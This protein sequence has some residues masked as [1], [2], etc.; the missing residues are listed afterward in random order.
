MPSEPAESN[1]KSKVRATAYPTRERNGVVWAY[2]GPRETPPPLPELE[3]NLRPESLVTTIQRE[4][5]YM[6][7]LEGDIDTS[8]LAFLHLGAKR[9]DDFPQGSFDYYTVKDRTPRYSVVET[10]YGTSYGA[11]RPAEPDTTYWRIAHFLFPF[12]T[13]IPTGLLGTQV[14]VRAWVPIDDDHTMFWSMLVPSSRQPGPAGF[15]PAASQVNSAPD[16]SSGRAFASVGPRTGLE[17]L[18]NSSDWLGRW[19]LEANARNDYLIDRQ[20]QAQHRA[21]TG[22]AGIHTQDQAITESMGPVYD[23][24]HEHLGTSDSMVI[25]TRR[26]LIRA[27]LALRDEQV[28]PPAVDQPDLYLQRSGGT[29]LPRS[30]DWLTATEELRRAPLPQATNA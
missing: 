22:I 3:P 21:Y 26:R 18:P 16:N 11:Y 28:T 6:Q 19:R 5:N 27:A 12:Y 9:P 4:C 25:R 29:I 7:G 30:A 2:L 10:E 1:F 8:H 15:N 17:M 14:L 13:M 24:S 23:R 20:E